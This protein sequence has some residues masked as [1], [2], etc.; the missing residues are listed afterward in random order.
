[1][2]IESHRRPSIVVIINANIVVPFDVAYVNCAAASFFLLL[3]YAE[4]PF[5]KMNLFH[6]I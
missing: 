2:K 6:I 4:R 5:I 1:M 3:F